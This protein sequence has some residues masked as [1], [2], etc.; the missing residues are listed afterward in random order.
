MA[1]SQE[2]KKTTPAIATL[3]VMEV[4]TKEIDGIHRIANF[5]VE[6]SITIKVAIAGVVFFFFWL[7]ATTI[8][9]TN[10]WLAHIIYL[11]GDDY[12]CHNYHNVVALIL[13]LDMSS[14]LVPLLLQRLVEPFRAR[15]KMQDLRY[16]MWTRSSSGHCRFDSVDFDETTSLLGMPRSW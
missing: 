16:V 14:V 3:M 10:C 11:K 9:L 13:P 1:A 12:C 4:S 15:S 8:A 7:A 2:K 6:T 5:C